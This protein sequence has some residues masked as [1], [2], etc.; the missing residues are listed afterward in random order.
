MTREDV[1][2]GVATVLAAMLCLCALPLLPVVWLA[3]RL[4]DAL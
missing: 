1:R 4:D 2:W 3:G